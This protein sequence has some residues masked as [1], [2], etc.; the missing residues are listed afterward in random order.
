VKYKI[1]LHVAHAGR[2]GGFIPHVTQAML[3]SRRQSKLVEQRVRGRSEAQTV[4]FGPKAEQP[5]SQPRPLETRV[6]GKE[7]AFA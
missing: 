4:D 1:G 6:T 2:D 5:F 7:D 3:H